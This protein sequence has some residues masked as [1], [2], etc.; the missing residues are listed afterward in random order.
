MP[1]S[2][3]LLGKIM[4]TISGIIYGFI[5]G[6]TGAIFIIGVWAIASIGRENIIG[7]LGGFLTFVTV[8]LIF[9]VMVPIYIGLFLSIYAPNLIGIKTFW[10]IYIFTIIVLVMM[11]KVRF[12]R[13]VIEKFLYKR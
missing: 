11:D 8:E 6:V 10:V 3:D 1:A 4:D 13:V 5:M 12:F 2:I 7:C 9:W